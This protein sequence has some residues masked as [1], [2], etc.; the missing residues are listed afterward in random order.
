MQEPDDTKM[1]NNP[2]PALEITH[3]EKRDFEKGH[4]LEA[5]EKESV[6]EVDIAGAWLASPVLGMLLIIRQCRST[7]RK[8]TRNSEGKSTVTCSR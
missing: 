4:A 3:N 2:E 7:R 1:A 8:S 6:A 5:S